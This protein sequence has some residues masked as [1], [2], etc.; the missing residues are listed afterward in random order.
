MDE[1]QNKFVNFLGE[2]N[3]IDEVWERYPEGGHEG[4]YIT[5]AGELLAWNKYTRQWGDESTPSESERKLHDLAGDYIIENDL[6]VGGK[7]IAKEIKGAVS[8]QEMEQYVD[9]VTKKVSQD[10]AKV[11]TTTNVL[12]DNVS[13]IGSGLERLEFA[14]T[15]NKGYFATEEALIKTAPIANEGSIAYVGEKYPFI[16][17]RFEDGAWFNTGQNGGDEKV[18]L[19]EYVRID[20]VADYLSVQTNEGKRGDLEIA[21]EKGYVIARFIDGHIVTA[22]FDSRD[23]AV[24]NIG[25]IFE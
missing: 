24:P 13:G 4:D 14:T 25:V 20:K 1:M 9:F 16:L 15:K 17:Y 11:E 2:F 5:I 23:S 3:N 8:P 7:L 12:K 19:S 6:I 21:D 18:N 10:I 22:K